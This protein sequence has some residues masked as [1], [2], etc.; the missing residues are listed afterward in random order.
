MENLV[1]RAIPTLGQYS[2]FDLPKAV[3]FPLYSYQPW[4]NGA[5]RGSQNFRL[6]KLD[7]PHQPAGTSVAF[8]SREIS[9]AH[10]TVQLIQ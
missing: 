3:Q 2:P 6:R 8:V 10:A 5:F 4:A 1:L 9:F 7:A